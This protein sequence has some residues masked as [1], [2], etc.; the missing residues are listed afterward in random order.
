MGVLHTKDRLAQALKEAGLPALALKAASGA[1]D[2]YLS[3]SPTPQM[4]LVEELRKHP[5]PESSR[6]I[7]QVYN[8]KFDATAEESDEWA[9]SPSGKATFNALFKGTP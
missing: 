5:S 3:A 4:D 7:D 8:G 1:Y 6:L 2:D 9:K